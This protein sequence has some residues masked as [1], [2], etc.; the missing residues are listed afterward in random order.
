MKQKPKTGKGPRK[1][2]IEERDPQGTP[3]ANETRKG[4]GENGESDFRFEDRRHWA[5]DD[6]AIEERAEE[7]VSPR[8]PTLIDEYRERTAEAE[9]RLQEYIEAFKGFK[10][11]QEQFR[12]RLNR[13]VDRRVELKFGTLVNELLEAV[14][15]MD[16]A[17]EHASEVP[18]AGPLAQG[19]ELARRRFLETL[20]RHGVEKVDPRGEE[21]DPNEAEAVRVDPVDDPAMASKVTKV[22]RPGYRLGERIIR[23]ARVAV[24]HHDGA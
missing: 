10:Q 20:E 22:L 24:G 17:L 4:N 12:E 23:P 11:E 8:Q 13:D 6:E 15:N 18:E 3:A 1:I 21:F 16:L 2:E 7:Q 14:D 9:Q 19:V 5:H